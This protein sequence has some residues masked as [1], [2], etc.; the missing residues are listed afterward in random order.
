MD[1]QAAEKLTSVMVD[2][3]RTE[4]FVAALMQ[5]PTFQGLLHEK[6]EYVK[7]V[8]NLFSAAIAR[9]VVEMGRQDGEEK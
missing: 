2:R 1:T 6:R 9:S 5:E 8:V 4:G 3:L 7:A